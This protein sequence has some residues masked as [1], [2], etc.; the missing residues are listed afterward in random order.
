MRSFLC[1]IVL[2]SGLALGSGGCMS[3]MRPN[4]P[5]E[6]QQA[7]QV[8]PTINDSSDFAQY[9]AQEGRPRLGTEGTS[10]MEARLEELLEDAMGQAFLEDVTFAPIYYQS[11]GYTLQIA[12]RGGLS[13][14]GARILYNQDFSDHECEALELLTD[15]MGPDIGDVD[16]DSENFLELVSLLQRRDDAPAADQLREGQRIDAF[17]TGQFP[18]QEPQYSG[19]TMRMGG[20][21]LNLLLY[22]YVRIYPEQTSLHGWVD[23]LSHEMSHTFIFNESSL[24]YN[25]ELLAG[26]LN[27][28]DN[29]DIVT[30]HETACNV[31]AD[32]VTSIFFERHVERDS[33]LYQSFTNR[34][35]ISQRY[36]EVTRLLVD[37]YGR[38]SESVRLTRRDEL[39]DLY[40]ER[41]RI[42]GFAPRVVN[43]AYLSL[44]N[45]YAGANQV[46]EQ[47]DAIADAVGLR[48]FVR[49]VPYLYT[50]EDLVIVHRRVQQGIRGREIIQPIE[51]AH[52]LVDL[53]GP[54]DIPL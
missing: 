9:F 19:F 43:E 18:D 42:E 15:Y 27:W 39:F 51:H 50:A 33:G 4:T 3:Y 32:R 47:L 11:S 24:S 7:R 5:Q 29:D 54:G 53:G 40:R 22:H 28:S 48:D 23:L 12:R 34:G 45:R 35:E 38:R 30:I 1:S 26:Y 31:V 25:A 2:S 44:Q 17:L 20:F 49:I 41:L 14:I 52:D 13:I 36:G 8:Q 46:R 6:Q 10:D 37:D 21:A 16:L